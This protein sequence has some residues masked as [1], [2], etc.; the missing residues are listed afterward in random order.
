MIRSS[1][2]SGAEQLFCNISMFD[3]SDKGMASQRFFLVEA[4][5]VFNVLNLTSKHEMMNQYLASTSPIHRESEKQSLPSKRRTQ[6]SFYMKKPHLPASTLKLFLNPDS[7]FLVQHKYQDA[8]LPTLVVL[9]EKLQESTVPVICLNHLHDLQYDCNS[10]FDART[11]TSASLSVPA[12]ASRE[13]IT[14]KA[15]SEI[16]QDQQKNLVSGE[17]SVRAQSWLI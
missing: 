7:F 14:M 8:I 15:E 6:G 11:D 5:E 2:I 4:F 16:F 13:R 9:F 17:G 1:S 10:V 12:W 3:K